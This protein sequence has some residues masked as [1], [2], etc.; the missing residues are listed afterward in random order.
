MTADACPVGRVGVGRNVDVTAL[1]EGCPHTSLAPDGWALA[2]LITKQVRQSGKHFLPEPL[3]ARLSEI[4]RRHAAR[5]PF[6]DAFLD[7]ILDKYDGRYA[8]LKW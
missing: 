8:R 7:C 2:D 3:L 1:L 5:D 6:F 4:R